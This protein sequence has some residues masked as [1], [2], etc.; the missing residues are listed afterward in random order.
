MANISPPDQPLLVAHGKYGSDDPGDVLAPRTYEVRDRRNVW[1]RV[2]A[3]GNEGHVVLTRPRDP[4]APD[5]A[6]RI[7]AEDD[8]Q[9]HTR[10]IG[11]RARDIV[12]IAPIER[13][14]IQ[15]VFEQMMDRVL[16]GPGQQ[17]LRQIDGYEPGFVSICL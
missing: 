6:M 8:L 3:Q 5:D 14:Q 4:P 10:R 16:E 9:E 15:F 11:R 13:G 7:R 12:L 17:L 1:T 2:A